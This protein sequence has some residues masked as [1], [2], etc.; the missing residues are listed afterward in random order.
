M[1]HTYELVIPIFVVIWLDAFST[2]AAVFGFIVGASYALTGIGALPSGVLADRYSSKRL[3]IGCMLGMGAGFVLVSLAPN[4][5]ILTLGLLVWGAAASIYHPAGL[6]LISRGAKERGTAFAYHGAAGNVGVATGPLLA[7]FFLVFFDWR[8]V[9]ALLVIPVLLAIAVALR[10]DFDETAGIDANETAVADGRGE[11][12]S[13]SEFVTSSKVLFTGGF[14]FVFLIGNLY[15]LYY[16]GA[17]TFLP[18]I[19]AGLSLFEP[20][21]I[22]G[23]SIEPSQYVYSGLLIL[24]G[25]GQYAGGKLV[26]RVQA[27]Y[28]LVGTFSVLVVIALVFVPAANAGLVPLLIISGLLGFFVFMEAPINQEVISKYVP[29]EVRGL[30]F[31]YTYV[32]VF[33]VGALGSAI[34]GIILTRAGPALLFLV[35]AVFAVAAI[36]FGVYL[37]RRTTSASSSTATS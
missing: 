14:V 35:L 4:I 8:V 6:S 36:L 25:A 32:A 21:A 10:L 33:G 7:A 2:T 28:A 19:L 5:V 30:S 17:F 23:Q 22:G 15:G 31:G 29:A 18:D 3:I 24:G 12:R 34:A 11:I 20:M 9:A 27:E 13:L 1:Y 37:I 26:D 16:R